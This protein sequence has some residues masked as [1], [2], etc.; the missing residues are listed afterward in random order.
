MI[1]EPQAP[2]DKPQ[3]PAPM[4]A[5]ARDPRV[6]V[7]SAADGDPQ[8]AAPDD[9]QRPPTVELAADRILEWEPVL[10]EVLISQLDK[11]RGWNGWTS[12]EFDNSRL[13]ELVTT[14]ARSMQGS[15]PRYDAEAYPLRSTFGFFPDYAHALGT[16]WKIENKFMHNNPNDIIQ[17]RGRFGYAIHDGRLSQKDCCLD[18]YAYP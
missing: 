10:D 12:V 2:V 4:P 8:V 17:P 16:W 14:N 7:A 15:A 18:S 9:I 13:T 3:A 1:R 11:A 5:A 6:P